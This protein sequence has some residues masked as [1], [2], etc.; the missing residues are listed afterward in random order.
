M[1]SWGE[2]LEE[3]AASEKERSGRGEQGAD[4]DGIRRRYLA[5]YTGRP[6][7]V[8]YTDW[9]RGGP[10]QAGIDL[11]DMQG[12]MEVLRELPGPRLDLILHSPGGSAE[13][14]EA[15]VHYLRTRFDDIRVFVPLA[16]MSAATMW[17][18]SCDRVVMG[19][20][21][22]LGP[23]D[24]QIQMGNL[25]VGVGYV[26][27]QFERARDDIAENPPHLGAWAPILQ[28]YGPGLL[29]AC[30][31]AESLARDLVETWLATYML[32]GQ[33]NSAELASSAA[34][35]FSDYR[36]HQS[37][38]RSIFRDAVREHG[39]VVDDL[40]DDQ[41]LQDAVL[42]VHHATLLT[43]QAPGLVKIIENSRGRAFVMHQAVMQLQ[44]PMPTTPPPAIAG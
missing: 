34:G 37:H 11:G 7:I 25:F 17:C 28:Q 19:K 14:T 2:I 3:F 4:A 9:V 21:S 26:R 24:P 1:P 8:Y 38:G 15:I 18:L 44:M 41:E 20:H 22:Q 10:P 29:E 36:S 39:V 42:S 5:A 35:F 40:E 27:D 13:A 6:V 23:I 12:I 31:K 33:A 30:E 16:A 43:L 32:H